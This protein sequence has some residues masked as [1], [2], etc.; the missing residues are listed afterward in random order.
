MRVW[1]RPIWLLI[2]TFTLINIFFALHLDLSMDAAHY[3]LYGK[4]LEA[5]YFDHPPLIGWLQALPLFFGHDDYLLRI[6]PLFFSIATPVSLYYLAPRFFPNAPAY[7]AEFC[8][9]TYYTVVTINLV[10]L[11][12]LPQ[13]I[14]MLLGLWISYGIFCIS[15]QSTWRAWLA[16]GFGLG[17][18]GLAEY[19]AVMLGVG[20][21]IYLLLYQ[22]HQLLTL[23]PYVAALV[24][25]ACVMPVVYW[26]WKHQWI[27]FDFQLGHGLGNAWSW[28]CFI[29]S[30]GA[31]VAGY[32]PVLFFFGILGVWQALYQWKD[33]GSKVLVCLALPIL[34]LF[35]YSGG[36]NHIREWWPALGWILLI[37][38]AV[39]Y[40]VL[41]WQRY[42]IKQVSWLTAGLVV[43]AYC[44]LYTQIVWYWADFKKDDLVRDFYGWSQAAEHA[45]QLLKKTPMQ[46]SSES[47]HLFVN[48]FHLASRIAWYSQLPV[49]VASN[50]V[51][52]FDLWFG[53]PDAASEGILVTWEEKHQPP[54][55][56]R[57]AG[58]FASCKILD[59]MPVTVKGRLVNV[60]YFY[61][62]Q[63]FN[64]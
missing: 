56:S 27:S 39:R 52:Q 30:L 11:D 12:P 1:S 44:F 61:H 53:K 20:I 14:L 42:W 2:A 38:I 23:K 32:G 57:A 48:N 7:F 46:Q 29:D 64:S 24:A 50:K 55:T 54:I 21:V 26:N 35:L 5:S 58:E 33:I 13:K 49:Q 51:R 17:L 62:C 41:N 9:I 37:P 43:V 63:H 18:A 31:Q 36:Y 40:A 8:V 28:G 45:K 15:Q 10:S 25:L 16:T 60:F 34:M 3:A 47:P 59:K 22:R 4:Y 6:W 19:T